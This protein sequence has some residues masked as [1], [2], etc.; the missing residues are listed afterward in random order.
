MGATSPARMA[1]TVMTT[2]SSMRVKPRLVVRDTEH[3]LDRRDPRG[4]LGPPVVAQRAH[5]LSARD[6]AQFVQR[7]LGRESLFELVRHDKQL[8]QPGPTAVA[9][10]TALGA[11]AAALQRL[12]AHGL[13]R[14]ER[15]G[16]RIGLVALTAVGTDP[17]HQSL[18]QHTFTSR[19]DEVGVTPQ[20]RHPPD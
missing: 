6:V 11:T 9:R 10:V 8:E 7:L 16:L 12:G 13:L 18:A 20:T 3:L 4:H 19:P 14:E 1:I 2:S 5:A 17:P 15:H